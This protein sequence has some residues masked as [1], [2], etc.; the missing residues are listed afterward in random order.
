MM[1][2]EG[3]ALRPKWSSIETHSLA[4][5]QHLQENEA[6]LREETLS[7]QQRAPEEQVPD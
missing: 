6:R 7:E 4:M 5:M 2:L 1:D 3:G